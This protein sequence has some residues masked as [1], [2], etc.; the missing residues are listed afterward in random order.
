HQY[1]VVVYLQ[2]IGN[3]SKTLQAASQIT[4]FGD[5]HLVKKK[6]SLN[7]DLSIPKQINTFFITSFQ[8]IGKLQTIEV[9]PLE[10]FIDVNTAFVQAVEVNYLYPAP[11]NIS[12]A[13]LCRPPAIKGDEPKKNIVFSSSHCHSYPQ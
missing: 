10:N 3:V 1:Q 11:M 13:R 12:E 9:S 5:N 2:T 8:R 7:V 6:L 4:I